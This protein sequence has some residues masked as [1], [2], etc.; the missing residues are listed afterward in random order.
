MTSKQPFELAL[1]CDF[2]EFTMAQGYFLSGLKDTVCYFDIF[3]RK[4][5]D[6]NGF[7]L[8]AGL[9]DVLNFVENL[10]FTQSDI[11]YLRS[12]K[13]FCEEFLCYLSEFAFNGEIYA[14]KEG[15]V[16]FPNEPLMIIKANAIEAQLLES[17]FLLS[18][19][20]QSLI[21][22]KANRLV[23]SAQGRAVL[24]FGSRRAHGSEAALKGARAAIIGGCSGTSCT[25][26]GKL[27]QANTSGT[28]AH[29]W[30]QMFENEFEAFC[31]FLELY[32]HNPSLLIDT[33]EY[34]K[35]LSNAIKAFHRFGITDGSVR[36]DSGDLLVLSQAIRKILDDSGLKECKIIASNTLDEFQ[37]QNLVAKN[38]PVDVFGVGE[39]LITAK[40]DPVFGCV[41]KLV[42]AQKDGCIRPK[43]KIS[44]DVEK[45]TIPHFKKLY[46]IYNTTTNTILYDELCI[47]NE[48]MPNLPQGLAAKELL[49]LVFKD[50]KRQIRRQ[51]LQ[52]TACYAKEQISKLDKSLLKLETDTKFKVKLSQKLYN[53]QQSLVNKILPPLS[54]QK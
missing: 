27:Y 7:A 16:V 25:L 5:P 54:S 1:L 18:L 26:A 11:Q 22:T 29:S 32:P 36:I 9:D 50:R 37:I 52:E 10:H 35:G 12:Q 34:K 43:I 21:A 47:Y 28:M 42:A 39:R 17:F 24:E 3:F 51:T 31:R 44:E 20:H 41:Y 53:L 49:H 30:V 13:L 2:Y 14:L 15:E 45:T 38:A 4:I 40:S 19:N 8:F 46:R 48:E 6:K 33:Y 23:R